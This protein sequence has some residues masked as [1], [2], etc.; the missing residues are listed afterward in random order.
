MSAG[1]QVDLAKRLTLRLEEINSLDYITVELLLGNI[2]RWQPK[3]YER[4]P[5]Y[6]GQVIL[7]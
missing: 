7:A 2:Q 5:P 4:N 1:G 3:S 6:L